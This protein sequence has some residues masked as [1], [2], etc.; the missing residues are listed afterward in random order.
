MFKEKKKTGN[1]LKIFLSTT[2]NDPDDNDNN[3]DDDDKN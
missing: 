2:G 3:D 1:E